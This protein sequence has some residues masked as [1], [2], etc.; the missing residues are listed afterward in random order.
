MKDEKQRKFQEAL[1][2]I[3]Y[4]PPPS[5]PSSQEEEEG[6]DLIEA[7]S[8][9]PEEESES[10]SASSSDDCTG[11]ISGTDQKLTR[12]QRKRLRKSKFKEATSHRRKIIGPL[13]PAS[14]DDIDHN[15]GGVESV[16]QNAATN[17][18][19]VGDATSCSKKNKLKKRR[20]SKKLSVA[21]L[22]SSSTES[23][24]SNRDWNKIDD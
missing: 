9:L 1:L 18:L 11:E 17:V 10:E 19:G 4:P 12:A 7:L 5:P 3:L 24:T 2:K 20:M 15:H 16:R 23:G 21:K 8:S 22:N 14:N 13:L 6:S